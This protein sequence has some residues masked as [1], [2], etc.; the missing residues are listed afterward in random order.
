MMRL[1][2][3]LCQAHLQSSKWSCGLR[4]FVRLQEGHLTP[5]EAHAPGWRGERFADRAQ[6]S[7]LEAAGQLESVAEHPVKA[8]VGSPD[9]RKRDQE[10]VV[11]RYGCSDEQQRCGLGV[12]EVVHARTEPRPV[13][14]AEHRNV[15]YEQ[16]REK[17][18]PARSVLRVKHKAQ[19]EHREPFDPQ[20]Q[21]RT[22]SRR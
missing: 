3:P 1:T 7:V 19:H 4:W 17:E 18:D 11:Q 14:V 10:W 21:H 16:E 13:Q 2:A 6:V 15:G 12:E 9:Q 5:R 22:N 8:D 20:P